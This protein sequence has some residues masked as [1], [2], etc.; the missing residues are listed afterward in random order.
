[1]IRFENIPETERGADF[2]AECRI[3][4]QS[5]FPAAQKPSV[6]AA[7]AAQIVEDIKAALKKRGYVY[8]RANITLEPVQKEVQGNLCAEKSVDR[9]AG[10]PMTCYFTLKYTAQKPPLVQAF[11]S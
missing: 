9:W 3:I 7:N 10:A 1:M 2:K 6:I 5:V 11:T 4:L 8:N